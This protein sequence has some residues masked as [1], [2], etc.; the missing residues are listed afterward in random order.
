MKMYSHRIIC[1]AL[2]LILLMAVSG[3]AKRMVAAQDVDQLDASGVAVIQDIKI[4]E[5]FSQV[6]I[7]TNKPLTYTSYKTSNPPK[8]FLDLA[9]TE[10]GSVNKDFDLKTGNIKNISVNRQDFGSGFLTRVEIALNK[11]TDFSVK[12]NPRDKGILIV[13]FSPVL[14]DEVS[15]IVEDVNSTTSNDLEAD[16]TNSNVDSAPIEQNTPAKVSADVKPEENA[17][18]SSNKVVN[19]DIAEPNTSKKASGQTLSA[20]NVLNDKIELVVTGGTATFNSFKLGKPDRLVVDLIGTTNSLKSD[21]VLINNFGIAKAR[22]GK[23]AEKLRIVFDS[24]EEKLPVYKINETDKGLAINFGGE[25]TTS[26]A[27]GSSKT[28][29]ADSG[30][31]KN[32]SEQGSI[33]SIEFKIIDDNSRVIVK[34]TGNCMVENPVQSSKGISLTIKNCQVPKKLQRTLDTKAFSSPVLS[35]TP[36][37]VRVAGGIDTRI[38]VKMRANAPFIGKN[39]GNTYYID[40]KNPA[41]MESSLAEHSQAKV[42]PAAQAT[43]IEEELMAV[44][45][46]GTT[47]LPK[48]IIAKPLS[49]KVYSGRKVTLEFSDADIRKIFQLIAEVS[50]LN[51]LIADDVTGTISIKLVN[52]PWDQALDVILDTKGLGMQRDGNIVQIKPK[53]KIMSQSDE[54]AAAKRTRERGMEL[55]SQIFD[56]NYSSVS[57]IAT[58]FNALKSERGIISSDART[59]RVIVKDIATALEDMRL[60]LKN[61]DTPEKQ[62]MIEARIVEASNSFVRD[63]GVQWGLHATDADGEIAAIT[64]VDSGFG[65]IVTPPPLAGTSGP[66]AALGVTFGQLATNVQL[67]M[68]LSAAVTADQIKIISTPR[69]VTLNNKPAKISQG[70]SIPYQTTSAEG[71]KTEFI[72]AAL[73][74]E[75]TPHITADG[76]IGMKI[77][78][79][80]NSAGSGSPPS[81]NKKEATTELLVK[82]GET[83]VIGGIYVDS[84]VESDQGV[85]FLQDIPILGWLFKSNIKTKVKNELLIFITPKIVNG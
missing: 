66:G 71:T 18:D 19:R 38:L 70:A 62:V 31:R 21:S 15:P 40:I 24:A 85:P 78:A 52:V 75:V 57:E 4:S 79:T 58:Q 44:S 11:D 43:P 32:L 13:S 60:L 72:E 53:A 63:I 1:H 67:D 77:K 61:L 8:V 17:A 51:F 7:S 64:R 59:N 33:E 82:N 69:V 56:V 74:L 3:C 76:S 47:E 27:L 23:T 83:T 50:N 48:S 65:G 39:E 25:P 49:K 55:R 54:E 12:T 35:I 20:V 29:K 2:I 9:Q 22:I 41:T 42:S 26:K 14:P 5:D 80:N 45:S 10:P 84:D 36:Y 16:S 81:I 34:S 73:T 68:R 37:Q 6:E 46:K 30:T 28:A